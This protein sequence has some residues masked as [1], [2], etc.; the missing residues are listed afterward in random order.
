MNENTNTETREGGE[1]KMNLKTELLAEGKRILFTS[2]VVL[3][4]LQIAFYK[5]P[6]LNT[7]KFSL[8]FLY[9]S[10]LPGYALMMLLANQLKPELRVILSFPVGL[11]VY[12]ISGYYLNMIWPIKYL[13]ALPSIIIISCIG[14]YY[15][16]EKRLNRKT[17]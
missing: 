9:F 5:E 12:A 11:A 15:L 3:V 14:V 17:R 13:I 2:A 1:K 7:A 4:I 10:L 6:F 8:S 16:H